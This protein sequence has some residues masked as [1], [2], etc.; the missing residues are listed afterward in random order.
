LDE[1]LLEY[2]FDLCVYFAGIGELLNVKN[3]RAE[4]RVIDVNLTGMI[5]TAAAIIPKMVDAGKGHF[6]GISSVA[7]ELFSAKAPS[8][9]ASKDGFSNPPMVTPLVNFRELMMRLGGQ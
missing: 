3:M 9:H 4:P 8:Y 7:D 1:L 2:S 5:R 6:I